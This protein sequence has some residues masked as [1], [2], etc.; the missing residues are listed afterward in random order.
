[1]VCAYDEGP[2]E[3]ETTATVNRNGKR[4]SL[5]LRVRPPIDPALREYIERIGRKNVAPASAEKYIAIQSQ[6]GNGCDILLEYLQADQEHIM[7]DWYALIENLDSI[8]TLH[9]HTRIDWHGSGETR[10][11]AYIMF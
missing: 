4:Y 9:W 3:V 6:D 5:E 8:K 10:D 7:T 11:G 1:M 2:Y